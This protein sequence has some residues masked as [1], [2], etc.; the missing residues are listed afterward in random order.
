MM[1]SADPQ[2]MFNLM[3]YV[4]YSNPSVLLNE[5]INSNMSAGHGVVRRPERSVSTTLVLPLLK[6]SGHWYIFLSVIQFSSYCSNSL[7]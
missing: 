6:L 4:S 5:S 1:E 7:M 3:I 2:L